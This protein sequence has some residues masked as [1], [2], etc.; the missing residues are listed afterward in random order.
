MLKVLWNKIKNW[1]RYHILVK[2]LNKE[3]DEN[4]DLWFNSIPIELRQEQLQQK[5]H[6]GLANLKDEVR[7][8]AK[9]GS[10]ES[11]LKDI[12]DK[13]LELARRETKSD[14]HKRKVLESVYIYQGQDVKTEEDKTKMIA[15]RIGHYTELQK[16]KEGRE[17]LK[18]A[19]TAY[20]EGKV[21]LHQQLMK[22]WNEKYARTKRSR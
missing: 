5:Y 7:K 10:L 19:R 17:L 16:Q 1:I 21:E 22:E 8:R 4:I 2:E 3:V 13:I 9:D 11:V 18:Q 6:T 12:G 15:T 14:T 20:Q